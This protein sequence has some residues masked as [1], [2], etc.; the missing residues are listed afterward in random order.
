M[1]KLEAEING[2]SIPVE[3]DTDNGAFTLSGGSGSYQLESMSDGR[4]LLRV[5]QRLLRIDGVRSNGSSVEFSINGQFV[6][7]N[8]RDEHALM[9][10]SMGFKSASDHVQG[11]LKAPMPGKIVAVSVAVD[12]MV[13]HG[14]PVVILE[15]MKMENE[16]K[17]PVGGRVS[18]VS[19]IV[20][21][22]VEKNELL[23]EIEP[24]G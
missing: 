8:V 14:Q 11:Q 19:A 4:Y 5:G 18:K 10:R 20:G 3:I 9:L 15:A 24:I 17:A 16:L 21:S 2:T 23:I 22:S 1:M 12:D 13:D 6:T 7:A